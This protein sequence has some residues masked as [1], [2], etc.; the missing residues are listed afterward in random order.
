MIW[1]I[2]MLMALV[3]VVIVVLPT[4]RAVSGS[5]EHLT[6]EA[7]S[8]AI[9]AD[10]LD[11]IAKDVRRGVINAVEARDATIEI[12]RRL[13]SRSHATDRREIRTRGTV[14]ILGAAISVPVLAMVYYSQ[15]GSPDAASMPYASRQEERQTRE[16]VARAAKQLLETLRADPDGGD[17]AGWMLLGRTYAKMGRTSDA[18]AAFETAT[19]GEDAPS[20]AFSLLAETLITAEN[21]VVT[22]RAERALNAAL[23]ADPL[24]PAGSFY[25]AIALAQKGKT[26]TAFRLMRDRLAEEDT[27]EAWTESYL[28]QANRLAERIGRAP[29]GLSD[30]GLPSDAMPG[31]SAAE[32]EAAAG[33]SAED[34]TVFIRSMVDRLA[35]RLESE[36]DDLDGW[37][38]LGRAYGVLGDRDAA[39]QAYLK[40]KALVVDLPETDPRGTVIEDALSNLE[41]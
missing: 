18:I 17:A 13:L 16:T 40:A 28:I 11:E 26:E 29:L 33:M 15:F 14:A 9:F 1:I 37:L 4:L 12:K 39:R 23:D 35:T 24:N 38:R 6:E 20:A 7:S 32:M 30:V 25:K 19:A 2:F 41:N 10:Q 36:P 5:R 8:A 22:P 27:I 21:G 34:R 3:A 31:P